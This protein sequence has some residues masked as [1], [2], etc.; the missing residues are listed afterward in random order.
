[1]EKLGAAAPL[2][3]SG[4]QEAAALREKWKLAL[5]NQPGAVWKLVSVLEDSGKADVLVGEGRP[6][7]EALTYLENHG[8]RMHYA[9]AR[10]QGLPIGSGHV[11]AT[12]KSLVALR[13]KRPGSRWKEA[14]GQ[15]VL[16]LRSLVLSER[17]DAAMDLT[18]APLRA[19]VQRAA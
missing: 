8:E 17:W 15:H 12:C 5:L 14:S 7:H 6:V 10:A 13:M 4:A 18:L 1:M 11:E 9:E 16:D 19:R 3:A 2:L